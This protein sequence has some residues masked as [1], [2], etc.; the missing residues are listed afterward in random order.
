MHIVNTLRRRPGRA[1]LVVA[2]GVVAAIMLGASSCGD[3]SEAQADERA[4][5]QENY[6]RLTRQHPAEQ[7]QYSSTRET[8]NF[9]IQTWGAEPGKLSYVYLLASNGQMI[10]YFIFEG[11]PVSYCASLTP[12]YR[13]EDIPGDGSDVDT[14]VPAPAM[15]GVYYSGGQCNAYYGR[16]A[17]SGAYME[18]TV[19]NGISALVF[20]Q[21][22]PR[23]DVEPLGVATVEN[24]GG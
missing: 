17:V 14:M 23:Q 20:D 7:A 3:E 19:G 16:D 13:W 2:A 11:L 9:W 5:Q 8:I 24:V 21:P 12:T 6:E 15:D 4:T 18:Y 22:L 1:T 10:G